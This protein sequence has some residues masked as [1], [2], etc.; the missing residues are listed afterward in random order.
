VWARVW[1]L[2]TFRLHA[3][4]RR[5]IVHAA[6]CHSTKGKRYSLQT[7]C[8]LCWLRR[9]DAAAVF[10]A[11]VSGSA[12]RGPSRCSRCEA[13]TVPGE[14]RCWYVNSNLF[15]AASRG[16]VSRIPQE[17]APQPRLGSKRHIASSARVVLLVLQRVSHAN[18]LHSLLPLA[19]AVQQDPDCAS[20]CR[21]AA[22]WGNYGPNWSLSDG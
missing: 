11:A 7:L 20:L 9:D 21:S 16:F 14:W 8:C 19:S 10:L 18:A 4:A 2:G 12:V 22:T 13:C 5:R 1:T 3:Q 17:P 15:I 6:L